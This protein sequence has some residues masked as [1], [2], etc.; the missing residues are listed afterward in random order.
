[1][2]LNRLATSFS[3]VLFAAAGVS[4]HDHEHGNVSHVNK[5]ISIQ[6]GDRAGELDTVNGSITI[7]DNAVIASAETVNG[8]IRV[9]EGAQAK[10]LETV[11]GSIGAGARASVSGDVETVNGAISLGEDAEVFGNAETVNGGLRLAARAHVVGQLI[12]HNGDITLQDNAR[13]EGG[14]LVKKNRSSWF[15]GKQRTP[16]ITI[17]PGAQVDG[18]L[19]F[20]REV[21]LN[22]HESARI[23]AVE[24][25]TAKRFGGAMTVEK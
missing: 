21:E 7:G 17:G 8:S 15:S 25:A 5:G 12:T 22:V 16:V 6:A 13:V 1:M 18:K 10:S 11:N 24:G 9:G 20:E 4:A 14:I 3:L 19:V 2:R 23:G